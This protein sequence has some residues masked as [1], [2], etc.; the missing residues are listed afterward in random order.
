MRMDVIEGFR[1]SPQQRHLWSLQQ[2]GNELPYRAQC[3]VLIEGS[4]D[5]EVLKAVLRDVADQY[6]ILRTTF[7]CPHGTD[8][9]LQVV[10]KESVPAIEEYD[11]S[12]WNTLRQETE[13]AAL[14]AEAGRVPFDLA[15]GPVLR[16][17]LLTLAADRHMLLVNMPSLCADAASLRILMREIGS[18]YSA[19]VRCQEPSSE[20]PQYADLAEWENDLLESEETQEGKKHWREAE[21]SAFRAP[22]LPSKRDLPQERRSS[23]GFW[24][25][26]SIPS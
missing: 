24:R 22:T 15:N 4:L 20:P 8:I 26:R 21:T 19:V 10:N 16:I 25:H 2:A 17:S 5:L 1:L 23:P 3:A 14:F 12:A 11:L 9:P 13:V 7:R 18:R 6:E